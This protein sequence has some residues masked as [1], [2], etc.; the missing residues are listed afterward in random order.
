MVNTPEEA[1]AEIRDRQDALKTIKSLYGTFES[2]TGRDIF[3]RFL[4]DNRSVILDWI[5]T[6]QL[7]ELAKDQIRHEWK[8][9]PWDNM[10]SAGLIC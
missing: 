3:I 6:E 10:P 7:M 9:Y 8:G 2:E 5:P 1:L 4:E